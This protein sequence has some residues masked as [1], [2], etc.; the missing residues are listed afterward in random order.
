MPR[1]SC[2]GSV[3]VSPAAVVPVAVCSALSSTQSVYESE[4]LS[5]LPP[6]VAVGAVK[7]TVPLSAPFSYLPPKAVAVCG[8]LS[9]AYGL[10]VYMPVNS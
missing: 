1:L 8:A 3:T 7:L 4:P 9:A 10:S 6:I 5:V 2:L